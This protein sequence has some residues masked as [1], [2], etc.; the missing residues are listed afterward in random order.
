MKLSMRFTLELQTRWVHHHSAHPKPPLPSCLFPY[1]QSLPD[2]RAGTNHHHAQAQT[3][4]SMIPF[5]LHYQEELCP[6]GAQVQQ[7]RLE[8]CTAAPVFMTSS[9]L[10]TQQ[11]LGKASPICRALDRQKETIDSDNGYNYLANPT[12]YICTKP[13]LKLFQITL[14][15]FVPIGWCLILPL[16]TGWTCNVILPNGNS[17]KI[18]SYVPKI[19]SCQSV[20]TGLN[21]T[22]GR[23]SV[24]I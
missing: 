5:R 17:F 15:H 3:E 1:H 23:N 6:P 24:I 11:K 10:R 2:K 14:L 21:M 16:F 18:R 20:T 4:V 22:Q 7:L 9:V 19:P 13:L 12:L 8:A